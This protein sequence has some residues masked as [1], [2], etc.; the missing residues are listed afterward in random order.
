[1]SKNLMIEDKSNNNN[2]KNNNMRRKP[3]RRTKHEYNVKLKVFE[4]SI[5]P[6]VNKPSFFS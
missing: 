3:G 5:L 6:P 1:M 2:K 4:E